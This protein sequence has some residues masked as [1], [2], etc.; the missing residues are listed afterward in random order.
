MKLTVLLTQHSEKSLSS[1]TLGYWM[2]RISKDN[3][4][5]LGQCSAFGILQLAQV[6]KA[7]FVII[8]GEKQQSEWSVPELVRSAGRC[9]NLPTEVATAMCLCGYSGLWAGAHL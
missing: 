4:I 6:S 5:S 7:P 1:P 8:L 3:I 2:D 9:L